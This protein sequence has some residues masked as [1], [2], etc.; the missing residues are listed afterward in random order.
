MPKISLNEAII[1]LDESLV[2]AICWNKNNTVSISAHTIKKRVHNKIFIKKQKKIINLKVALIV[3]CLLV[4]SIPCYAALNM[5]LDKST[6]VDDKNR[7]LIGTEITS[8]YYIILDENG[9]YSDSY[10]NTG[11]LEDILKA[12]SKIQGQSRIVKSNEDSTITPSSYVEIPF[13]TQKMNKYIYPEVIMVNNSACIFTLENGKGWTLNKGD[14][15][16]YKYKKAEVENVDKQ[17]MIIGYIQDNTLK[18]GEVKRDIEG[19]YTF[20]ANEKGTYYIYII[21]ASSDY[22]TIIEE[23]LEVDYK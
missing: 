2:E 20:T 8:D 9:V 17:T 21:S 7:A 12:N 23:S 10:G 4:L 3:S 6:I 18:T 15:I 19:S 5:F 13:K 1:D 14:S 16:T 22:Q 11:S